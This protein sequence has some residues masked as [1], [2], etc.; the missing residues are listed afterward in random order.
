MVVLGGHPFRRVAARWP[1]APL[2][3][4]GI[5]IG[6]L[7]I[8]R[9]FALFR[10]MFRDAAESGNVLYGAAAF[11]LQSLGNIALMTIIFLILA[12]GTGGRLQR[13]IAARPSR[14]AILAAS[15]FIAAGVFTL[16]YWDLRLLALV[17]L[18][19]WYPMAPWR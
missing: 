19:P 11:V 12:Y 18:I 2:V 3:F 6:G 8:G 7:S 5:L 16:L 10:T 13:W 15:A 14:L 9:P 1:N 17:D 4:V